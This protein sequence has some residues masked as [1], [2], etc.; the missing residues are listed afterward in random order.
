MYDDNHGDDDDNDNDNDIDDDDQGR[1]HRPGQAQ[2]HATF[3][4][5]T[6]AA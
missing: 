2:V 3:F 1:A 6:I 5:H 4:N